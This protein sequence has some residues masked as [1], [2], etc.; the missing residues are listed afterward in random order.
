[1][2]SEMARV[3]GDERGSPR[4]SS[5]LVQQPAQLDVVAVGHPVGDRGPVL[6]HEEDQVVRARIDDVLDRHVDEGALV[7][8]QAGVGPDAQEVGVGL[9]DVDVRVLG[10]GASPMGL[11]GIGPIRPHFLSRRS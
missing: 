8:P 10:L 5:G 2:S 1:M 7:G 6:L 4:T 11:C 9:E 3:P